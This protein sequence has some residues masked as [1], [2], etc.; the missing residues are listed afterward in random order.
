MSFSQ[1]HFR[2]QEPETLLFKKSMTKRGF[3]LWEINTGFVLHRPHL[4]LLPSTSFT[5]RVESKAEDEAG[6]EKK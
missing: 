2:E 4:L 6:V 3:I 5:G 1:V